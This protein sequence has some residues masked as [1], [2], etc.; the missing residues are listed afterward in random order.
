M[1]HDL[2]VIEYLLT[3]PDLRHHPLEDRTL[4]HLQVKDLSAAEPFFGLYAE[5]REQAQTLRRIAAATQQGLQDASMPRR[6]Y[7]RLLSSFVAAQRDHIRKEEASFFPAAERIL[8]ASD[9]AEVESKVADLIDPLSADPVEHRFAALRRN[10]ASWD[11][12][13]RWARQ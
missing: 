9:W 7:I 10:L 6:D 8:D 1:R 2:G 13:D 5:H 11:T 3:Y 12:D 4:E